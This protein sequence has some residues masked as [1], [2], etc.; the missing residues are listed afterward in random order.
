LSRIDLKGVD[1]V[2]AALGFVDVAKDLE[3]GMRPV[4]SRR[5]S[6]PDSST[7]T[8]LTGPRRAEVSIVGGPQAGYSEACAENARPRITAMATMAR[9]EVTIQLGNII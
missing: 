8:D 4:S 2:I 1:L 9:I 7:L 6:T 3:S 5:P